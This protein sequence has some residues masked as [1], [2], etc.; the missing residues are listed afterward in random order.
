MN[1][2][3]FLAQASTAAFTI[4][5]PTALRAALDKDNVYRKNIGVQL[6]TVRKLMEKDTV[7]TIKAVA[8]AGYKQAEL[9]GFPSQTDA[10]LKAARDA[11]LVVNSSHF[12]WDSLVNPTDSSYQDFRKIVDK[13]H[14]AGLKHLVV[15]YLVDKNR[16]TLDDYKQ[17][18]AHLNKGAELSKAAGIRLS[19]HNHAFEFQPL[20]GGRTGFDVFMSEFSPDMFFELDV[21]WVKVGGAEPTDLLK[22]LSGRVAQVHLKDLKP[23][24]T[25][26]EFGKVPEDAFQELGDG[27]LSW[28][29]ILKAAQAAGVEHCHVEQDQS[30]DPLAS[31]RQSIN[32]LARL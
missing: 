5:L 21:F 16:T 4:A 14:A 3:D 9:G 27:I 31:I 17:T 11:G 7:G 13:A 1:R 2:R 10:Q 30:P 22:Q 20:A 28:E 26:P 29:P 23:G 24:L 25:L 18:A 6:Y 19:Y 15:P 12:E 32:Y 8:A